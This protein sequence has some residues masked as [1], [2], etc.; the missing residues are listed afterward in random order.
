V[1][2]KLTEAKAERDSGLLLDAHHK[3]CEYLTRWLEENAKA[4]VSKRAYEHYEHIVKAH[5]KA[6][7]GGIKLKSLTPTCAGS[8]VRS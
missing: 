7:L 8:M 3:I 5:L 1:D 4:T 6:A 2:G